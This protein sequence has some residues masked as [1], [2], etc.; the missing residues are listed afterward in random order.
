ME[1]LISFLLYAVFFYLIMR[2]VCGAHMIHGS[3]RNRG[4]SKTAIDPVCGMEVAQDKG[5]S[6]MYHG[7]EYRFC[8]RSCLIKFDD[9][10][11]KYLNLDGDIT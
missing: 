10:P 1:E 11:G 8:S 6:K 4:V 5:F 7:N 2:F 9:S 3:H